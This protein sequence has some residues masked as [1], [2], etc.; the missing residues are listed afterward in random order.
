MNNLN[1]GLRFVLELCL[2]VALGYWGFTASQG[3]LRWVLG[4]GLP[5]FAALL[6]G[7]F[8]APNSPNRLNNPAR[9]LLEIT[10]FAT[11][12]TLLWM[13]G[14]HALATAFGILVTINTG[15]LILWKQ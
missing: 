7:L 15:L 14:R 12:V 9:L 2:L 6:W 5:L 10:L 3:P 4:L 11:G 1:I 13:A 8:V